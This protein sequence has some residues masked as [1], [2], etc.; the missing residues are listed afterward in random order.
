MLFRSV[1]TE[2]EV[3]HP[4][5]IIKASSYT[6]EGTLV[7]NGIFELKMNEQL[8]N[9]AFAVLYRTNAQSRSIEEA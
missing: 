7:A 3:C 6:E 9:D 1:W 2:N 5:K 8:R 4:I